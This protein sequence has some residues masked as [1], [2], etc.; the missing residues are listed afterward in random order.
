MDLEGNCCTIYFTME[1]IHFKLWIY[2]LSYQKYQDVTVALIFI[3][4]ANDFEIELYW[5]PFI[6]I[7]WKSTHIL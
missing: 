3:E 5:Y 4:F 1:N 2:N 6:E 7:L